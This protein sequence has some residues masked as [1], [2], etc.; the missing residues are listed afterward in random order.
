[1]SHTALYPRWICH[2][3]PLYMIMSSMNCC[4]IK[5]MQIADMSLGHSGISS[6]KLQHCLNLVQ[7]KTWLN[8]RGS[9]PLPW[10][11]E[12]GCIVDDDSY[13]GGDLLAMIHNHL[14]QLSCNVDKEVEL[15]SELEE[16]ADCVISH[17]YWIDF[18]PAPSKRIIHLQFGPF[19]IFFFIFN[20]HFCLLI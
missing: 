19:Y 12:G 7:V 15:K 2:D 3:L 9:R 14:E 18:A 20:S 13:Q 10:N 6:K 5:C 11:M 1:M 8:L 16:L 17:S 4:L